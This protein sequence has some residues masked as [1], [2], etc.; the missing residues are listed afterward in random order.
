MVNTKSKYLIKQEVLKEV[1]KMSKRELSTKVD[2]LCLEIIEQPDNEDL[3]L[4]VG[5]FAEYALR[6]S[7]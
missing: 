4:R 3:K 6:R 2:D 7:K 1:C 5:F